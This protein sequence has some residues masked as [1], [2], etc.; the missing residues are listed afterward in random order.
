MGEDM[1]KCLT[2]TMRSAFLMVRRLKAIRSV[3]CMSELHLPPSAFTMRQYLRHMIYEKADDVT[4]KE[5]F[6]CEKL[7]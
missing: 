7:L 4:V 3:F 1:K 5:C 6:A 2:H